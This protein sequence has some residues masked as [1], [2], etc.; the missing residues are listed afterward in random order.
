MNLHSTIKKVCWL[1]MM[2]CF[3]C[4]CSCNPYRLN[5]QTHYLNREYLASFHV[6]TPD[7]FKDNP[8]IGQRMLIQ[9]NIPRHERCYQNF[10]L[11]IAIRLRNRQD[12]TIIFPLTRSKG[13]YLYT[14]LNQEFL[15]SGG[16]ATYKVELLGDGAIL[17]SW[18]HPL[19]TE[20]IS[21]DFS[22]ENTKKEQ[23]LFNRELE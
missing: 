18:K 17:E 8:E 2:I 3:G 12:K 9:W 6:H 22:S 19:W 21:F 7:P 1:M 23:D 15:T 20:L 10:Q 11:N 5:V 4:L 16:I 13:T 14:L